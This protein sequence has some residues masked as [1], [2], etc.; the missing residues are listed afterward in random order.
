MAIHCGSESARRV[1]RARN[2]LLRAGSPPMP[3]SHAQR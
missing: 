1:F 2:N 3:Q